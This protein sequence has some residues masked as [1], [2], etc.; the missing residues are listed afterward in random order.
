MEE[1]F[2]VLKEEENARLE[3]FDKESGTW[4]PHE[5][6]EGGTDTIGWA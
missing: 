1:F 3:G 6:A 5:S 2:R 4:M